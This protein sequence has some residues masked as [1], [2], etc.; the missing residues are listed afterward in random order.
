ME[1]ANKNVET[2]SEE[3]QNPSGHEVT[4]SALDGIAGGTDVALDYE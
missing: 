3:K 2:Q 4:E 1:T